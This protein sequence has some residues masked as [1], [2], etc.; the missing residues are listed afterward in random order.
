[1]LP[2][3]GRSCWDRRRCVLQTGDEV[4]DIVNTP[5]WRWTL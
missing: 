5:Q 3:S 4:A 2:P 1:M